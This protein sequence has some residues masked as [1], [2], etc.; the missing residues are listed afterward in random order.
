V[1]SPDTTAVRAWAREN[2]Y[3]VADRGRLPAEI[4]DAYTAATGT[5]PG[6][7][8]TGGAGTATAKPT[9]KKAAKKAAQP[10]ATSSGTSTGT[11][12]GKPAG[13]STGTSAATTAAKKTAQKTAK[14]ADTPRPTSPVKRSAAKPAIGTRTKAAAP[15]PRTDE[16]TGTPAE[17]TDNTPGAAS[18]RPEG[19]DRRLVALAAEV[20][21]LTERVAALEAAQ[22]VKS[23]APL[24]RRKK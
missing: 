18:Q 22:P 8:Q 1:T 14:A 16:R 3:D 23:K 21:A 17:T 9:A 2:G 19:E 10:S 4:L 15:A 6:G 7:K 11:S 24:F 5:R 12:T 13:T 20:A